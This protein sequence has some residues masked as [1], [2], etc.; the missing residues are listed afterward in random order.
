MGS[1]EQYRDRVSGT[2]SDASWTRP[3]LLDTIPFSRD[4][5]T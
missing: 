1:E 4:L 5:D 2:L 3:Y